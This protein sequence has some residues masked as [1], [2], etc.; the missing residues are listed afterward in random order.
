MTVCTGRGAD[1]SHCCWIAGKPCV[2]LLFN[3]DRLPRCSVFDEWGKLGDNPEWVRSP[4][5]K[6][7]AKAHPGFDCGD[8]P[9]KIPEVMAKADVTG[10]FGLCCWG[11]GNA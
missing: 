9:Q 5:G 7:Y 4:T 8:W 2:F 10:P 1:G 3:S 11:R 6:W